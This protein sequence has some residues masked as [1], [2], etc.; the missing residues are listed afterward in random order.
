MKALFSRW[1]PAIARTST[2]ATRS[3][4]AVA[5][6]PLPRR[7]IYAATGLTVAAAFS[8]GQLVT[9]TTPAPGPTPATVTVAPEASVAPD[10]GVPRETGETGAAGSRAGGG[11]TPS[12]EA[13]IPHGTQGQQARIHLTP[14]Q[15]D[16][17]RAIIRTAKKQGLPERAAVIGV[18][19]SLQES[20]LQNLGHLGAANDHDSLGLFQQRP[21]T[22]WGSPQQ[23]TDPEYSAGA[24]YAGLRNVPDW[25]RLPLTQAAQAVQ[26][27]AY[28]FAYA[29]WE[30]QAA[31]VVRDLWAE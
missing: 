30:R 12:T 18:A 27:S 16:N 13:L 21:S 25:E 11:A 24:F 7:T 23:V 14:A 5:R 28:P 10:A 2:V 31:E 17:A 3:L 29:Q 15:T 9:T 20:K 1:L 26:V 19:T 4:P 22:G 8:G 6:A